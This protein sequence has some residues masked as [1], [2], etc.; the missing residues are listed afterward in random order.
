M[1]E[2]AKFVGVGCVPGMFVGWVC[3]QL[4]VFQECAGGH[5]EDRACHWELGHGI[6]S[7]GI[8]GGE[9]VVIVMEGSKG[10]HSLLCAGVG[11]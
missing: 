2:A 3:S 10:H 1:A 9:G 6:G 4:T 5:V 8:I 11:A 7:G